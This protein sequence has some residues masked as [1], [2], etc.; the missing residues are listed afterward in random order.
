MQLTLI[1]QFAGPKEIS[2]GSLVTAGPTN[3][4][5]VDKQG[6]YYMAGKVDISS[7]YIISS[8]RVG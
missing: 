3:S 6:V 2:M 4:V 1:F 7:L 5:V 8:G